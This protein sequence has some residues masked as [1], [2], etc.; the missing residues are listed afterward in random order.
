MIAFLAKYKGY[1]IHGA[2]VL[3]IFL[4]PSVQHWLGAHPAYSVTGAGVWGFVLHWADGK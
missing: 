2:A 1:I 4:A 3:A